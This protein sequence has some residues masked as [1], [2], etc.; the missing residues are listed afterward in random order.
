MKVLAAFVA[1][2]VATFV[3]G[4][5]ASAQTA[6]T[7]PAQAPTPTTQPG[8]PVVTPPADP[9]ADPNAPAPP[10]EPPIDDPSPQ[11][12][13]V[14]AKLHV[15]DVQQQVVSAQLLLADA[16][17]NET[18]LRSVR[19]VYQHDR[20]A[21]HDRFTSAVTDAYVRQGSEPADDVSAETAQLFTKNALDS[22]QQAL[23][24]ADDRLR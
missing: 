21:T 9:S 20:D 1:L 7:S 2:V 14:L 15:L 24:D 4:T 19:D 22:D 17:A 18:S 8:L 16:K 5:F 23:R 3:P 12:A 6:P 13:V 10:P 11:V